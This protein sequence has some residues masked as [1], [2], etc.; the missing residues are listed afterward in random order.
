MVRMT[1]D[2]KVLL[3]QQAKIKKLEQLQIATLTFSINQLF[4]LIDLS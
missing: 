1:F 3:S 4:S 2:K